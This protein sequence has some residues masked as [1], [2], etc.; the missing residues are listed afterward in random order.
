SQAG[1]EAHRVV[2]EGALVV[3]AAVDAL[4]EH[5][6]RV[7]LGPPGQQHGQRRGERGRKAA[8]AGLCHESSRG[9]S[10]ASWPCRCW[11][12]FSLRPSSSRLTPPNGRLSET[13][14]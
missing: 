5:A 12:A 6:V 11:V 1:G 4:D 2:V 7:A 10:R 14:R 8:P 3:A 13:V 9:T